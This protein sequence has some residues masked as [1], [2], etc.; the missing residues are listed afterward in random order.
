VSV[1]HRHFYHLGLRTMNKVIVAT[2]T[3]HTTHTHTDGRTDG[4]SHAQRR[5]QKENR[6]RC[7]LRS[8]QPPTHT[9]PYDT[10]LAWPRPSHMC[11]NAWTDTSITSDSPER[12]PQGGG[13]SRS[14]SSR[15]QKRCTLCRLMR[16]CRV[17]SKACLSLHGHRRAPI[18]HPRHTTMGVFNMEAFRGHSSPCTLWGNPPPHPPLPR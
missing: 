17:N 5:Q 4:R 9:C 2:C 7:R 3:Q 10:A 16:V 12:E 11:H 13:G 18:A 8:R 1:C 6:S 15:L 14:Q